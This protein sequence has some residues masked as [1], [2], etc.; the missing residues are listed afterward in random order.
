MRTHPH[1]HTLLSTQNAD[2]EEHIEPFCVRHCF[3]KNMA[4]KHREKKKGSFSISIGQQQ[5]IQGGISSGV[6]DIK[7]FRKFIYYPCQCVWF[8]QA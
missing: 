2:P 3:L 1:T 8:A 4:V 6:N 7:G 5:T